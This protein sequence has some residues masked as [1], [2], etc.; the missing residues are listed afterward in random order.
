MKLKI[1]TTAAVKIAQAVEDYLNPDEVAKAISSGLNKAAIGIRAELVKRLGSEVNLKASRMKAIAPIERSNA[2]TLEARIIVKG[3]SVPLVEYV[4]NKSEVKRLA[5][6]PR[7]GNR[8]PVKVKIRKKDRP[9]TLRTG[10]LAPSYRNLMVREGT[11]R[12]P[13]KM[14]HGPSLAGF[15]D[16]ELEKLDA[17]AKETV[18]KR[19]RE[20]IGFQIKKSLGIV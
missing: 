6:D 2:D 16:S 17:Y 12:G 18:E 4:S 3:E 11:D 1:D 19:L 14:L 13:L 10:F 9:K 20:S 15:A 8:K 7:T 5:T